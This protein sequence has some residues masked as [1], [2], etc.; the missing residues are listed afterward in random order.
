MQSSTEAPRLPFL[1]LF[2]NKV[3][4]KYNFR[5]ETAR[6][7]AL[8][9]VSVSLQSISIK[10][11]D[12][13]FL[14]KEERLNKTSVFWKRPN[15][16]V[17]NFFFNASSHFFVNVWNISWRRQFLFYARS[18]RK[19]FFFPPCQVCVSGS[20]LTSPCLLE[21][22]TMPFHGASKITHQQYNCRTITAKGEPCVKKHTHT[23]KTQT[24]RLLSE[25]KLKYERTCGLEEEGREA[26]TCRKYLQERMQ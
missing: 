10:H 11:D 2:G 17:K 16:R 1:V 19:S 25:K 13:S 22:S 23:K 4:Q 12:R 8:F 5:G 3:M 6:C 9:F 14:Q 7:N 18:R 24:P 26:E 20:R 21:G 15:K